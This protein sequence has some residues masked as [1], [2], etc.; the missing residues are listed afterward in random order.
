MVNDDSIA[1]RV[2]ELQRLSAL[3]FA[4]MSR[5]A[6]LKSEAH[7]GMIA[8]GTVKSPAPETLRLIARAFGVT[9]DWL[10]TGEGERPT[11]S[12]VLAAVESARAAAA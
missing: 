12:S 4:E 2:L 11:A 5:V 3:D 7:V 10:I 6:G 8:R 1:A 9:T